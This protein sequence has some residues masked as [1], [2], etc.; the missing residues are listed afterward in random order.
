M[1][2]IHKERDRLLRR[3]ARITGLVGVGTALACL[4]PPG[5]TSPAELAAAGIL[6]VA[7]AALV[8]VSTVRG[9]VLPALGIVAGSVML[10]VVLGAASVL[11]PATTTAMAVTGGATSA[12]VAIPLIVRPRG[13][14]L[15]GGSLAAVLGAIW[16]ASAWGHDLRAVAIGTV[17]G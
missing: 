2:R 10:M 16:V 7:M 5:V 8:G 11:D 12:S 17:A 4:L 6:S 1:K 3:L 15:V 9:A 14:L 13:R